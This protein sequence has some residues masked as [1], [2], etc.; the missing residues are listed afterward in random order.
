MLNRLSLEKAD[1]VN[2]ARKPYLTRHSV[3]TQAPNKGDFWPFERHEGATQ[4]SS[5]LN[6]LPALPSFCGETSPPRTSKKASPSEHV[7][8]RAIEANRSSHKTALNHGR[9][10]GNPAPP[11]KEL[12]VPINSQH[13][14]SAAEKYF[15]ALFFRTKA[16]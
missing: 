15:A 7:Y 10:I 2:A 13:T 14:G 8:V 12:R 9:A 3:V 11:I 5:G 4:V 1:D 6:H 16:R